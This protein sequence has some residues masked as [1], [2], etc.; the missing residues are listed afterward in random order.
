MSRAEGASLLIP[1][2]SLSIW[3]SFLLVWLSSLLIR[4]G[5]LLVPLSSINTGKLF[6]ALAKVARR[7]PKVLSESIAEC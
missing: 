6:I 2:N 4:L 1:L 7:V 3:L 5:T